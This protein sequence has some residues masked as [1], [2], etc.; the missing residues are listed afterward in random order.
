MKSLMLFKTILVLLFFFGNNSNELIAQEEGNGIPTVSG[1]I[2]T[3]ESLKPLRIGFKI[4]APSVATLNA[5][6]LTPLLNNR[7]AVALDYFPLSATISDV[8]LKLNNFEFGSNVYLSDTGKGLYGGLSYYSF[9]ADADVIDVDYDDGTFGDGSTSL[10]FNTINLKLGAKF[11]K[12]FYFRIELGYGFGSLPD[13][14]VINA[15]DSNASTTEPIE[16]I[17]VLS[18]SGVPLFNFGIGFAFL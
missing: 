15:K 1:N 10:K 8:E 12:T 17:S 13:E 5:E 4:G 6:Y 11:G 7:V 3:E 16:D 18:A 2:E 9:N 14:L